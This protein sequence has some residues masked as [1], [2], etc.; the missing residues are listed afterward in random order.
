MCGQGFYDL[1]FKANTT[2]VL[3][4]FGAKGQPAVVMS[5]IFAGAP[6]VNAVVSLSLHPPKGG[7]GGLSWQFYA[8]IV[9]AAAGPSTLVELEGMV[10]LRRGRLEALL[11]V[12][13]VD[14]AVDREGTK[15]FRTDRDWAFVSSNEPSQRWTTDG[16]AQVHRVPPKPGDHANE[17]LA[18]AY[19]EN[20]PYTA[21]H[22]VISQ[23]LLPF[24]W[25]SGALG[26][27]TYDV[28]MTDRKPD[29]QHLA[30][31]R[32]KFCRRLCDR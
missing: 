25:H 20:L 17:T 4:A 32:Q 11:K 18:Q 23:N 13:D 6:I 8:G 31:H 30:R 14:G 5:I 26:G 16:F 7:F 28:L 3:L 1:R 21:T 2:G 27:R 15:W 22:L 9:L 24:L 12:L 19:E 29:P 10:N